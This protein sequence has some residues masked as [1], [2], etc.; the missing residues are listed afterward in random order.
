MEF[1]VVKFFA[2]NIRSTVID[3]IRMFLV[4]DLL[5][6]YNTLHHT[7]KKF[8]DYLRTDQ[9]K[10]LLENWPK[11]TR[12]RN[13]DLVCQSDEKTHDLPN[14]AVV[15]QSVKSTGHR[16]SDVQCQSDESFVGENLHLQNS[17]GNDHW[18]ITG[19]IRFISF[20]ISTQGGN[21]KGYVICEELLI[22]CLMWADPQFA[23]SVY[24][25]L[26][27]CREKNNDFLRKEVRHLRTR[28]I[29]NDEDSQWT[30]VL[31]LK[32]TPDKII[33]RS[34]YV[35][36]T[37][38]GKK[39]EDEKIYYVKNLPNGHVFK[40]NAYNNLLPVIQQY[41]GKAENMSVFTI[42]KS[43]WNA[44]HR[45]FTSDI[46]AALKQTRV[47]LCWRTDLELDEDIE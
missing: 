24:T 1:T 17:R 37:L 33:L 8:K 26:K 16:N 46:R 14:S 43:S 44:D 29:P 27:E 20:R 32:D 13:S 30:Y 38:K 2:Y 40:L 9:T 4:S 45:H 25:F 21:N 34:R 5:N 18:N 23:I 12:G 39:I 3:D 47:D 22:A 11:Y 42:P 31:T 41:D 15:C 35:H 7:N 10:E 36:Q 6:Q 19:V 28:Y